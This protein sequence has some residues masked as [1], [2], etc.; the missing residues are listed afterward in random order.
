MV[1]LQMDRWG[2]VGK[3]YPPT[4]KQYIEKRGGNSH[5][6]FLFYV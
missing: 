2:A 4:V 5:G 3:N 6:V 1:S